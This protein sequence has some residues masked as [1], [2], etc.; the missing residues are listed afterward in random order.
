M[1]INNYDEIQMIIGK[2][3]Y[4]VRKAKNW[5]QE[6][7]T[8]QSG[9]PI[10]KISEIEQGKQNFTLKTF[11]KVCDGLE[12]QLSE[13]LDDEKLRNHSNQKIRICPRGKCCRR[14][15]DDHIK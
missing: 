9:V 11:L 13:F 14:C 5:S 12:M 6:T 10:N 7:L 3:V 1:E 2:R 4:Y 8:K 15:L